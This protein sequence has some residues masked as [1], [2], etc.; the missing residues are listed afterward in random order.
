MGLNTLAVP[1]YWSFL[2]P[3]EGRF[4]YT[5]TDMLL[6]EARSRG[7][8]LILLWFGTWKN[9]ASQYVPEWVKLQKKRFVWAES[10]QGNLTRTL[11]PC[12]RET[13]E[14]DKKAFCSLLEHLKIKGAEDILLGIQVE[15]EPG[16][17]G[18]PRDYSDTGEK[19][20][21][22]FVPEKLTAWLA[23][24]E[25][26]SPVKKIWLENGCQT[27]KNW[28]KTFGFFAE[29][30]FSAYKVASFINE[31]AEAGKEVWKI[32]MYVNV[33]LGEMY[34]RVPGLDYPSG[35]ATGRVLD[36]WKFAAPAIDSVCPDIYFSDY[37]TYIQIVK[38][39]SRRDNPLYI[40][41]SQGNHLNA[42]NTLVAMKEYGLQG[43]HFF[44]VDD[45]VD[46]H[47]ELKEN[48]QEFRGL[49]ALLTAMQPM[50]ETYQ[51]TEHFFVI[52]QYEGSASQY[53]DFGD[54]YGR[55]V[56]YLPNGDYR[57]EPHRGTDTNHREEAVFNKLAKGIVV[58]LG[59]GEFYMAGEGF[60]LN[61]LRRKSIKEMTGGVI[62]SQFQ[63]GRHQRYL[64]V[65]EGYFN[66][67]GDYVVTKIRTGDECDT[68]IWMDRDVGVVHI[69]IDM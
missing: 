44:G 16:L 9:G 21:S 24:T 38:T 6:D 26:I 5:Q 13:L 53:L 39:Y 31:I 65:E 8:K 12:C 48:Y 30:I 69:R 67:K 27:G 20:F 49:I 11:S 7:I 33:W 3:E 37:R 42:M 43:I 10:I 61:L 57:W 40:P 64:T 66:E 46:Q 1:V 54:F 4:D 17:L 45:A 62:A 59:N 23:R 19:A 29:E 50:I 25:E 68:G 58:Y 47:G 36:L 55:A 35:G 28:E 60:S 51:G 41:E 52:T 2:E 22:S 15:N 56:H 63:N 34:N 32:P 14:A 18:T